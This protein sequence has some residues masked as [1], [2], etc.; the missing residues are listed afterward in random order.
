MRAVDTHV[1]VRLLVRDDRAQT[2]A[3]EDFVASGAW[4]PHLVLAETSRVLDAVH[5][6]SPAQCAIAIEL[7][8]Q[9]R[10]LVPERPDGVAAALASFRADPKLGF[11]D[12]L[13]VEIA[14]AAGHTP[15][16]TF[17]RR[18]ATIEGTQRIR[19]AR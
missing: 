11:S 4:V 6:R 1:V 13:I 19:P 14:R 9:H 16:G 17:D 5:A 3:A 15:V 7:L 12:Y 2:A 10:S 8:L 18:L